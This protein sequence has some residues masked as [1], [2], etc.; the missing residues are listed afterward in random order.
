MNPVTHFLGGW[1]V[2]N[3]AKLGR[4]DRALV[5]IA[6]MAPDADGFGIVAE[7]LTRDSEHPIYWWSDYHHVFGHN[8]VFGIVLAG[9]VLAVAKRRAVTAGLALASVHLHLVMDVLGGR[10]PDRDW[11]IPYLWPVSDS[12]DIRWSGQWEL[13]AWPN[14]VITGALLALM[15]YLAWRRGHSPVGIVSE[16][17]DAAFV[18][19]LRARFPPKERPAASDEAPD[20]RVGK[21]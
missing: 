17:A 13:N 20:E 8:L 12:P 9:V 4:R 7:W 6:G 18:G 15:F 21:A 1:A 16:R 3:T 5:A 14:F 11:G 10:G 19:A 2:A